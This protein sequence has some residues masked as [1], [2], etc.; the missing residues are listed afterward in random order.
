[1]RRSVDTRWVHFLLYH[2]ICRLVSIFIICCTVCFARIVTS[3]TRVWMWWVW[4]RES[5]CVT[6]NVC[7]VRVP[8]LPSARSPDSANRCTQAFPLQIR[9]S[10]WDWERERR[11]A[12][13]KWLMLH[14]AHRFVCLAI[15]N[16]FVST[17]IEIFQHNYHLQIEMF[18]S[19]DRIQSLHLFDSERR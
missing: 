14:A 19:N 15:L 1:M 2:F 3:S 10:E 4:A 16:Q 11:F 12:H 18:H 6:E 5:Y 7:K 8:C 9:M 17:N 13:F